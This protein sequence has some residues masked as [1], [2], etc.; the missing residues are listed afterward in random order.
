MPRRRP[1]NWY[2]DSVSGTGVTAAM[3]VPGSAPITTA[4][5]KRLALGL[6]P[7]LVV[8]RPAAMP[9]PAHQGRV[10]AGHLHAVDAEVEAVLARRA[11]GPCV[12]TSGQVISG[13]GSSGQQV[14]TGSSPRSMSPPCST[15]SWHGAAA[16]VRGRIAI[17]VFNKRQHVERLAPAARR[18]GLLQKGQRLADL[19][20]LVGLA[21][22]APGDPLDRA[23][24]IDQHRHRDRAGLRRAR[25]SRTAPPGRLRRGG[26]SGSRSFRGTATPAPRP[27]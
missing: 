17:T 10:A 7:A 11:S 24:Q 15:I 21:V 16:T 20:Q 25:R 2:S 9:Q 1:A 4:A 27:A 6:A 22:H 18:L 3:I 26:G 12:T 19:A 5:G 14:W 13:A 8:L 23:E